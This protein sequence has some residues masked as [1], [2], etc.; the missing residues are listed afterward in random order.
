MEPWPQVL[1]L[2]CVMF[3]ARGRCACGLRAG[4]GPHRG[5]FIR[6]L[7]SLTASCPELL[8]PFRDKLRPGR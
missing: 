3:I 2:E 8:C 7:S 6:K 4:S 5:M 1:K